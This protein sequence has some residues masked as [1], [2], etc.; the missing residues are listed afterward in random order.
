MA[1]TDLF[2]AADWDGLYR[3]LAGGNPPLAM[4]L[5][6]LN[7]IFLVFYIVRRATAKN[8]LRNN[9]VVIIQFFLLVANLSVVLQ[10]DALKWIGRINLH[11]LI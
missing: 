6:I 7:T 1:N 3:I 10:D 2:W 4:Q 9:T 8:R 5:L 11:G